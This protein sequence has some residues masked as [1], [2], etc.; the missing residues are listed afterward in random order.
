MPARRPRYGSKA[1][2]GVGS[3]V[4]EAVGRSGVGVGIAVADGAATTTGTAVVAATPP[5]GDCSDITP[6]AIRPII[7][8]E[9]IATIAIRAAVRRVHRCSSSPA[10]G[11]AVSSPETAHG[12]AARQE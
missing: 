3:G 9:A 5:D 6:T 4:G 10:G 7:D 1:G 8:P 12:R 2:V 11:L